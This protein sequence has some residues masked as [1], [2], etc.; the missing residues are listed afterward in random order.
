MSIKK[1]RVCFS[2]HRPDRLG[3][4]EDNPTQ[5]ATREALG[6]IVDKLVSEYDY[7]E[8]TSGMAVGV[9]TWAAIEVLRARLEHPEKVSLRLAVPFVGQQNKWPL[10]SQMEWLEVYRAADSIYFV[11][12]EGYAP[13][14][15]LNRNKWMV[16][17]CDLVV[18][19][20]NGEKRGGT[21]HCIRYASRK[22]REIVNLWRQIHKKL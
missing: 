6:E 10:N 7:V 2:G 11:D 20:W 21:A 4:Y 3:G 8:F 13:W 9:D 18:A 15:L 17:N 22:G 16:D 14:K 5:K 12:E 19:V 1:L